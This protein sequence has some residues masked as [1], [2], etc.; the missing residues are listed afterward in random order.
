ML[1]Y[2]FETSLLFIIFSQMNWDCKILSPFI[3]R[4]QITE[5]LIKDQFH[6]S[7]F[8]LSA[9]RFYFPLTLWRHF[10]PEISPQVIGSGNVSSVRKSKNSDK[11][12]CRP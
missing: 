5:K 3:R 11:W 2:K 7:V 12:I 4:R 1:Q 10:F 6:I 8:T 9:S